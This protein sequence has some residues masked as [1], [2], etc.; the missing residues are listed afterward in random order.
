MW[1][2]RR[3]CGTLELVK[4]TVHVGRDQSRRCE[5]LVW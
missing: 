4:E 2:K 5:D 3:T 1:L